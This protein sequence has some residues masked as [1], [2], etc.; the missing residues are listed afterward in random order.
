MKIGV[1]VDNEFNNDIRVRKEVDII[2]SAGYKV[3]VLCF[4]FNKQQYPEIKNIKI[5]RIR[6]KRKVKDILFFFFNRI[7]YYEYMWK[8]SIKRFINEY[9]IDI[10][11]THDLYMSKAAF[12]GSMLSNKN[13]PVILDLHENYPVAVKG[14]NWTNGYIRHYIS[15]PEKWE[16]KEK[17]YLGYASRI[18]VLSDA[19]KNKL[20]EKYSFLNE[21]DI[22]SFPNVID[23]KRFEKYQINHQIKRK[24]NITLFYFG[25]IAERRGIFDAIDAF[26]EVRKR[27]YNIN[28]LIIGPVDKSDKNRFYSAINENDVKNHIEYIPWIQVSE[29]LSYLNISDISLAPF[30]KNPQHE[31]GVAN[32]I[33]QYMFGKKPIIASDCL[34]QKQLINSA[35]CGLIYKTQEGFIKHIIYLIENP[36]I[37]KKMGN[38]GY[39]ELY[40]Q[41]NNT[42]FTNKLIDLYK[43]FK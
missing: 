40:K 21:S 8:H 19:Y 29:L 15:L 41:F 5:K 20:L 38:N 30:Y 23:F 37:M 9:S 31:S 24:K 25:G 32:K 17:E 39:V 22:I 14:Y 42:A 11:H 28:F 4:G 36:N 7:P 3:Y 16:I 43:S 13:C 6:I 34:P 12:Q 27:G 1:I 26:R 35:N 18:I 33:Y 10:I 2:K